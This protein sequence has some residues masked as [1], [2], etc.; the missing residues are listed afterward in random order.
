MYFNDITLVYSMFKHIEI[1]VL[2]RLTARH[3][4]YNVH[5]IIV[6][7][8]VHTKQLRYNIVY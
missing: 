3:L 1:G 6:H 8:Q 5:N 2:L 7:L 4:E